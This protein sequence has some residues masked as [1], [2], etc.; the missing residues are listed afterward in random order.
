VAPD[1]CPR[2]PSC[3]RRAEA[4]DEGK[5]EQTH[6]K[7]A[8]RALAGV[9]AVAEAEDGAEDYGSGPEAE[10]ASPLGCGEGTVV[11]N[12]SDRFRSHRD[13]TCKIAVSISRPEDVGSS[14]QI[15][16]SR[17]VARI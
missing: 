7:Q 4:E 12:E 13:L 1:R 14:V 10:D 9:I 5:A 2:G 11:S 8:E 6:C 3:R 16:K 15:K 17:S